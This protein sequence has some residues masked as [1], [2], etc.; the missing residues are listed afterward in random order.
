MQQSNKYIIIFTL[1]MTII[2]GGLLALA[3]QLLKPAQIKS[4]EL[5]TK[6]Q[7]LSA[8]MEVGKKDDVL[9]IYEKRIRSI[10]VDINGEEITTD[11]KGQP[12]EAEKIDVAKYFKLDY[13]KRLF[14][15][16][17]YVNE[18]N[19]DKVEAYILPVYGSGLWDRIWGF[20]ALDEE[21][22]KIKGVSFGHKGETPGLGA[23]IT[24]KDIQQRYVG[25]DIYNSAGQFVS[26]EMQ[27]GENGGGEASIQAYADKPNQV[28]GMSGATLTG[29]GVNDMLRKYLDYYQKYIKKNRK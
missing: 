2:V 19:P 23:R 21:L 3:N 13:K 25:K 18:S 7:I 17:K 9:G 11:E 15:V 5:D 24:E 1:I 4:I 22:K 10:V 16:F 12:I 20:V 14:P 6:R 28:D 27:K 26:V 29:R 8:V